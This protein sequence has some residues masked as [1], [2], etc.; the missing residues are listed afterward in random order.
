MKWIQRSKL[1][2][3]QWNKIY[4]SWLKHNSN[5]CRCKY[6]SDPSSHPTQSC[7][8]H[9]SSS[10]LCWYI[11]LVFPAVMHFTTRTVIQN[12]WCPTQVTC[13]Y[14]KSAESHPCPSS[15][16]L[17]WCLQHGL[18]LSGYQISVFPLPSPNSSPPLIILIALVEHTIL[19][20]FIM[21]S[22]PLLSPVAFTLLHPCIFLNLVLLL[23]IKDQI[24]HPFKTGKTVVLSILI[25][26]C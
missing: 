15:S 6:H 14:H 18:F 10:P 19:V 8:F 11:T 9:L 2:R 5:V 12:H 3:R 22:S 16:I 7:Q 1:F 26:I 23:K 25:P 24:L 20:F 21:S 17:C 13:L 4:W